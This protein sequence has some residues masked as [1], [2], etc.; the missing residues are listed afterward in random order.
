M[1]PSPLQHTVI[2]MW[3]KLFLFYFYT[4]EAKE[5]SGKG[6]LENMRQEMHAHLNT[7]KSMFV[8]A[9]ERML[10]KVESLKVWLT[11]LQTLVSL[12]TN[13]NQNSLTHEC[14][15]AFVYVF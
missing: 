14:V 5:H 3:S 8:K 1:R 9:K 2:P 11:E 15:R 10:Y 13:S 4:I 6:M 12:L 7:S